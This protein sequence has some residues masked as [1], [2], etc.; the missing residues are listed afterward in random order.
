VYVYEMH[1]GVC[2]VKTEVG[3]LGLRAFSG[4]VATCIKLLWYQ[5]WL[6]GHRGQLTSAF[7]THHCW[8]QLS[9]EPLLGHR[10]LA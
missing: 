2:G 3:E 10:L 4:V 8:I 7:P 1:G 6:C 9:E 5:D